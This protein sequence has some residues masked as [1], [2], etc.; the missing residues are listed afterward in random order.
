L[1]QLGPCCRDTR[2]AKAGERTLVT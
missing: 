2:R 1:L